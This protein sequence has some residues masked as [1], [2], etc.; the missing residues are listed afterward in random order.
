MKNNILFVFVFATMFNCSSCLM[1]RNLEE[2]R[3]KSDIIFNYKAY[4]SAA[5][6]LHWH[7]FISEAAYYAYCDAFTEVILSVEE[8]E[9]DEVIFILEDPSFIKLTAIGQRLVKARNYS[10]F[11]GT[12]SKWGNALSNIGSAVAY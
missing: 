11:S 2:S 10:A 8:L 12:C 3:E 5:D 7:G 6:W 4:I 9:E 1:T